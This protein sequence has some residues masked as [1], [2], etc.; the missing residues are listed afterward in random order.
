M[1]IKLKHHLVVEF[2]LVMGIGD[3]LGSSRSLCDFVNKFKDCHTEPIQ[4]N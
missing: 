3:N 4:R 2:R 1:E